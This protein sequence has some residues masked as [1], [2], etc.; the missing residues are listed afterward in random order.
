ML[1]HY[2]QS[3]TAAEPQLVRDLMT[4][5][6]GEYSAITCYE[7]LAAMAPTVEIKKRILEIRQDEIRHFQQFA[8]VYTCL[9]GCSPAPKLSEACATEYRAG[10]L[11]SFKD[12]QNTVD[13]YLKVSDQVRDTY[14]KDL[15]RRTAADEQNHAVWFLSFLG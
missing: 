1:S 2:D 5:L 7:K 12:E 9:T 6:N 8:H 4:S 15:F 13:Y 11:A 14:V 3:R 10:V